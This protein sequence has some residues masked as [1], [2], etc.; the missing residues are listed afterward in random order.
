LT[1]I[2][3][4]F[5]D[6]APEHRPKGGRPKHIATQENR[7]KVS[8]LLAFGWNN[9]RLERALHVTPNTLRRQ[10]FARTAIPR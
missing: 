8:M 3:D 6:P 2:L 7:S 10:L 9:V 5:C 4:V 1:Q